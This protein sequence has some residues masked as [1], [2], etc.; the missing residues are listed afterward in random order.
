MNTALLLSA[1]LDIQ[2]FR[3]PALGQL[4][5]KA[6]LPKPNFYLSDI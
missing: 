1:E 5:L 4:V 3:L 2:D 6:D